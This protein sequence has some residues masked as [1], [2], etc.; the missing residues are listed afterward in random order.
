[1]TDSIRERY[2]LASGDFISFARTLSDAEWSTRVPCTPLWT[3]RD[4]LSHVSGVPDDALAGRLDGVA[5][6]PWTQS[7]VERNSAETVEDL[8]AR[9]ESQRVAFAEAVDA[10]G[11]RRPPYDCHT[12]EHDVRHAIGRPGNRTSPLLEMAVESSR[13]ADWPVAVRIEL[14]DGTVIGSEDAPVRVAGLGRFELFR[15]RVGRRSRE[16]VEAYDWS[17]DP[18]DVARV[19]QAWFLF[20][21]SDV[22]IEE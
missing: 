10:M 16:Q 3:A 15:S 1:M 2:L 8:L 21:P 5:S 9:W 12:H 14:D 18:G 4:V 22:P 20:G 6:E 19:V 7:Q 17:G 13:S 11:E